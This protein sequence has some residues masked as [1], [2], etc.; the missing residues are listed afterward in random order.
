MQAEPLYIPIILLTMSSI[1]AWFGY[2]YYG[3]SWTWLV[4][5][6]AAA[7]GLAGLIEMVRWCVEFW[8]DSLR[9]MNEARYP[10]IL[11]DRLRLLSAPA[12]DVIGRAEIAEVI[13]LS[14]EALNFE[15]R[16]QAPGGAV[17][18]EFAKS[19]VKASETTL[20]YLWP[21]NRAYDLRDENGRQ[22]KDAERQAAALHSLLVMNSLARPGR[23][24]Q[25]AA[26][27][28]TYDSLA[29]R[30]GLEA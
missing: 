4:I 18:W 16:I 12:I 6:G 19:M 17:D 8:T 11:A 15:W 28:V 21:I 27:T 25:A 14:D 7:F 30:F 23:G 29:E 24:N 2:V 26:L 3:A 22:Y 13:G 10:V 5:I 20:P 1:C 9:A